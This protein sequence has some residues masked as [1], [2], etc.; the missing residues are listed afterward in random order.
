MPPHPNA[1]VTGAAEFS[2]R[3][4]FDSP[5]FWWYKVLC[6]AK[7]KRKNADVE[8]GGLAHGGGAGRNTARGRPPIER[9]Q[10]KWA[11]KRFGEQRFD[12]SAPAWVRRWPFW[13]RRGSASAANGQSRAPPRRP[14]W[15]LHPAA[16]MA[17]SGPCRT[18]GVR[19]R[20]ARLAGTPSTGPAGRAGH[21]PLRRADVPGAI[22]HQWA[23]LRGVV[24]G[25]KGG[26]GHGRVAGGLTVAGGF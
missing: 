8:R 11:N 24:R 18:R 9:E 15:S 21:S 17:L 19:R 23:L 4:S 6:R 7:S 26:A 20:P 25:D 12:Q 13:A 1:S 5:P 3:I 2:G 14:S 22:R 10:G 16:W